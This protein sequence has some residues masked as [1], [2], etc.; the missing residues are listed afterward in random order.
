[1]KS[2]QKATKDAQTQTYPPEPHSDSNIPHY[3][4]QKNSTSTQTTFNSTS[5]PKSPNSKKKLQTNRQKKGSDDPIK[6]H[7]RFEDLE[8]MDAE[9]SASCSQGNPRSGNKRY[10]PVLPPDK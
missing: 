1:M 9:E 8:D 6:L 7:N 4:P 2:S 3:K 10:T 5:P